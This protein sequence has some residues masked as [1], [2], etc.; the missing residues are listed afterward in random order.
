MNYHKKSIFVGITSWNSQLFLPHCLGSLQNTTQGQNLNICVLDNKSTDNSADIARS[1]GAQVIEKSCT[2]PQALSYLINHSKADYTLL[3][4]SDVI[5]LDPRWFKLCQE[6]INKS[7][8]LV[9][10]EDIGCGP[11]T[12]PFG[13][14][15]PESSFMFFDTKKIKKCRDLLMRPTRNNLLPRYEFDFNG[16]HVTHNIPKILAR[17]HF[18]WF[19]MN[20]LTSNVVT[21]PL[22]IPSQPPGVWSEEL[23]YLRYGLGNFYSIDGIVT[24]YHNWYDRISAKSSMTPNTTQSKKDFPA[25]FIYDYTHRFLSDFQQ[26]KLDLP[27]DLNRRR[28]P[29][30]L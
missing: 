20:V 10:P 27:T 16:P 7:V 9:S 28:I 12:R 23:A 8:V 5:F 14:N 15:M 25:D 1:Y 2:Q 22:F 18:R 6:K 11:M 19:A 4:H 30:A 3:I 24:H 26:N 21:Q 13:I 17:R 29:K